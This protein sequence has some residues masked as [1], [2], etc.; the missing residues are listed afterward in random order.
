MPFAEFILLYVRTTLVNLIV[1]FKLGEVY[2]IEE[3][4]RKTK[5]W[6]VGVLSVVVDRFFDT[7]ALLVL[8]IPAE[9]LAF[10]SLTILSLS[11]FVV[12]AS[13]CIL[14]VAIPS[15]FGYLNQYLIQKKSSVRSL[16]ALRVLD[17]IKNWYDFTKELVSGRY[18]LISLSSFMG[19]LCEIFTLK[20][21]ADVMKWPFHYSDFVNYVGAVLQNNDYDTL[22]WSYTFLAM[23]TFAICTVVF[24]AGYY[25]AKWV[26][27]KSV[28]NP[29]K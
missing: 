22:K 16:A 3:I 6:Q 27:K 28:G 14:Y 25:V 12:L 9:L 4:S 29:N 26:E 23:I 1:P 21:L 5:V 2:R 7:L 13:L 24:H 18:M 11:F 17:I 10:R 8:L 15:S 20:M 19:W